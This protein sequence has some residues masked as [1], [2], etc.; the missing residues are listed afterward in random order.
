MGMALRSSTSIA[1]LTGCGTISTAVESVRLGATSYL[2]KPVDAD[3]MLEAFD[4]SPRGDSRPLPP[5]SRWPASNGNT[6]GA[7][8]LTL[9]P[10]IE[11]I[12]CLE[13]SDADWNGG[14]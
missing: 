14:G 11:L 12:L 13:G 2:S 3:Q 1:A 4:E 9:Y 5:D 10:S 6:I 8:R 7:L